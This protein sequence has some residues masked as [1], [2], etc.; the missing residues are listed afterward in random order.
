ME[1]ASP[2][3]PLQSPRLPGLYPPLLFPDFCFRSQLFSNTQLS[4]LPQI[5]HTEGSTLSWSHSKPQYPST[6]TELS[7]WPCGFVLDTCDSSKL[8]TLREAACVGG[9]MTWVAAAQLGFTFH[10]LLSGIRFNRS[11]CPRDQ[12]G[13]PWVSGTRNSPGASL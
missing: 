3:S 6:C 9:L 5:S 7:V 1:I 10:L 8:T 2:A 11:H 12:K 13:Q 4:W